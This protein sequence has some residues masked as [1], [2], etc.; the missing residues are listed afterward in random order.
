M[1]AWMFVYQGE[2]ELDNSTTPGCI[3]VN[4]I[5]GSRVELAG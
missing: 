4:A 3:A 5:D 1:P 2:S